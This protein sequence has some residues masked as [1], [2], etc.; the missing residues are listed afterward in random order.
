MIVQNVRRRNKTNNK[1]IVKIEGLL[2]ERVV[3]RSNK[4]NGI[5][6]VIK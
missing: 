4:D 5:K 2:T 3:T 6:I 1:I